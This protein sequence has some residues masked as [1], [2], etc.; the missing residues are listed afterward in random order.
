MSNVTSEIAMPRSCA[1]TGPSDQNAPSAAPTSRQPIAPA[2]EILNRNRRSSFAVGIGFGVVVG[3]SVNGT[4][5]AHT[6]MATI[7]NSK[8]PRVSD[9]LTINC[10][11]MVTMLVTMM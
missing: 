1:K 9:R 10:P 2:G 8:S 11:A 6:S 5:A 4:I 3:V 7:A